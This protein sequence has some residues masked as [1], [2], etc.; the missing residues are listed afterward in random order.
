MVYLAIP[1]RF[2]GNPQIAYI[3]VK[4]IK[5]RDNLEDE[6]EVEVLRVLIDTGTS[7]CF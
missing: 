7:G 6:K 4:I 1:G 5:L 2:E 3:D